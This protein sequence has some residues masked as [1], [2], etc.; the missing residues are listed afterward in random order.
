M[1]EEQLPLDKDQ[2]PTLHAGE[3][4]FFAGEHDPDKYGFDYDKDVSPDAKD[5]SSFQLFSPE[6]AARLSAKLALPSA[7]TID[8]PDND[9]QQP[10]TD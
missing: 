2:L 8:L 6:E 4:P 3:E 5:L 10:E 9:L 7:V 1:S